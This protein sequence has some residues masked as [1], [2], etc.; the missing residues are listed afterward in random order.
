MKKFLALAVLFLAVGSFSMADEGC[1]WTL[2]GFYVEPNVQAFIPFND[3]LDTT[4]Y[5]GGKAGYQFNEW[6]SAEVE[7]GWAN[8]D[9]G[10]VGDVTTVPLLF[11]ARVDLWPGVYCVDPY[12]FGGIGIGFNSIDVT[13]PGV[14]I[15]DSLAGQVG[16]GAEY[17][18]NESLSGY[19]DI[20]FYFNDPDL[21]K[22]VLGESDVELN[23]FL[24]GGGLVWRF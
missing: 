21:N 20:R 15:D 22:P 11:N 3:N 10:S 13:V 19:I 1:S 24:V 23:A 17:H 6:F 5:A 18:F 14:E 9:L 16:A 2:H 4:V 8:P 7:A 12:I